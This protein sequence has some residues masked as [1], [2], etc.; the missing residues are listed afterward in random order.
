[1]IMFSSSY[2]GQLIQG[3]DV[4]FT[5]AYW[6]SRFILYDS[7][8]QIVDSMYIVNHPADTAGET[9][10]GNTGG[11]LM[12]S[13]PVT[14]WEREPGLWQGSGSWTGEIDLVMEQGGHTDLVPIPGALLLLGSGLLGL[15]AFGRKKFPAD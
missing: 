8:R 13:F 7:T 9:I 3:G 2:Q 5:D 11:G 1:M 15:A 4:R 12:F 6:L 10:S 14:W